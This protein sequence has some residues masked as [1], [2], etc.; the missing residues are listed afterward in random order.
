MSKDFDN[1]KRSKVTVVGSGYVGM[2]ISALLGK[3]NYVTVLDINPDK[4]EL[5]NN[6]KS[7]VDDSLI[8]S[9]ICNS[10]V[11]IKATLDS[12][13]AY[14]DAEFIIIATPTNFEDSENAFDTSSI[15]AV[16]E[17][18]FLH[19]KDALIVI[20]STVPIGYTKKLQKKYD[21]DRI[22]F[23]PEFLREGKALYDNFYPSRIIVGSKTKLAMK[24]LELLLES[25]KADNVPTVLTSSDEAEAIKLFSNSFLAMRVAFFNELDSF[26]INNKL[27]TKEIIDGVSMDERIGNGYNNPSFGYGGYCLPKD[28]KQLLA[29]FN[30]TPQNLIKAIV[31]SNQT[32]KD[33]LVSEILNTKPK[34][35]GVYLLAMKEG[36]DNFRS[37]AVLDLINNLASKNIRIIIY[38][39]SLNTDSFKGFKVVNDID[40][41]TKNS[42]IIIAN[43]SSKEIKPFQSKLFTRD[44]YGDN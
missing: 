16:V 14:K 30:H 27:N 17:D 37:A 10:F 18:I 35:V 13:I 24:F 32:R 40:K 34:V 21:S 9:E 28:T 33:Y 38:E 29:N 2:A 31:E 20:K 7:T 41:F 6:K 5:I 19:N 23:S 4:V 43:R 22:I 39:P 12:K 15:E 42:D 3:K 8:E 44:I 36:S 26:S 1:L 25:T 11:K